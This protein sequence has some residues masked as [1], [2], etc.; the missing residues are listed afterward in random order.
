MGHAI[1]SAK[2]RPAITLKD[3]AARAGVAPITVSRVLNAPQSVSAELREQTLRAIDELGY[4]PNRFAGALASAASRIVPVIVPSLS[5]AVFIEVIQGIQEVLEAAK[6]QL[7]LGNTQYDLTREA[8]LVATPARL[9]AGRVDRCRPA[10]RPTHRAV[11][12]A[13]ARVRWWRSW[14]M[15]A[16]RST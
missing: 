10:S 13:A 6:Y 14:S 3:V 8:E 7:L 15:A 5:N 16:I 1:I 12:C 2:R 11:C 4:V 9:V